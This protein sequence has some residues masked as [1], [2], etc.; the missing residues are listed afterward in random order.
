MFATGPVFATN[1]DAQGRKLQVMTFSGKC[2]SNTLRGRHAETLESDIA[3]GPKFMSRAGAR[4][5][6]AWCMLGQ[7]VT[8]ATSLWTGLRFSQGVVAQGP[9]SGSGGRY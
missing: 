9:G 1:V 7:L 6:E 4:T 3:P 5:N 8:A 2:C